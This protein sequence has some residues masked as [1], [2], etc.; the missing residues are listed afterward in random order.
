MTGA[1]NDRIDDELRRDRTRVRGLH[2]DRQRWLAE[3]LLPAEETAAHAPWRI[4]ITDHVRVRF[5]PT[6]PDGYVKLDEANRQLG[7]ARQTVLNQVHTGTRKRRPR[8]PRQTTRPR[9]RDPSDQTSLL[10]ADASISQKPHPAI[11]GQVAI[12]PF[13]LPLAPCQ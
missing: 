2:P 6:V 3:G 1:E 9:N 4:R 7:L 11:A 12:T 5:V 8:R 10:D 13:L